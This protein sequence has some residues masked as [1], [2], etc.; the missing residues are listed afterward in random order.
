M[1][2]K[3][4]LVLFLLLLLPL[5]AVAQERVDLPAIHRIKAEAF[6]TNSKAMDYLFYLTDVYGPRLANS[7]NY[8]T[9]GDWAVKVLNENGLA[10]VKQEKWGPFGPGWQCTYYAG[11]MIEPTYQPLIA[12]PVA[13]TGGTNGPVTGEAVM[14]VIENPADMAKYKGKLKGRIVFTTAPRELALTTSPMASRYTEPELAALTLLPVPGAGRGGRAAAAATAGQPAMTME[15]RRKLQAVL[16]QFFKDEQPAVVVQGSRMGFGGTLFGG[17]ADRNTKGNPPTVVMAAEHYNRIARLL[18]H[19]PP[20]PVKLTFDIKTQTFDQ[21]LDGFNITAE[22]PGNT[23]KDEVV[24]VGGHLDSW[25]YGTGASDNAVGSAITMEVMRILKALNLKMDRT[26]RMALWDAEEEGLLGSAAYVKQHFADPTVMKP[27]PE[28]A[29]VAAYFNIDNGGGKIRGIY[30]QGNDMVAPIFEKWLEPFRDLGATT[31]T[32]RNTTGTD[33]LSFDAV[34]LPGFQFIQD[35]LDY[36]TLIHHSNMDVY[37][38]VQRSDVLQMAA[39]EAAFVYNAA[40]RP[41]KLP[42]KP[43]PAPRAGRG[44]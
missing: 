27:S 20:V 18:Q 38:R 9:A 16:A 43:L 12:Q 33:H 4:L 36:N 13:W 41:E 11:H 28:H 15:E 22:I 1:S 40:T 8:K 5:F 25:H 6:G 26:V 35:D 10:N 14:A 21:N 7:P 17:G 30:T 34:G 31:V 23:K 32:N 44:F 2:R 24:I 29:N 39:I 42:R 37:D 3:K 19:N